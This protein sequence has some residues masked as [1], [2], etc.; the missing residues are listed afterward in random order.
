MNSIGGKG[1]KKRFVGR[2]SG[3][4]SDSVSM[5]QGESEKAFLYG[6]EVKR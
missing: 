1:V 6:Q 4:G 5:L 3:R 2:E